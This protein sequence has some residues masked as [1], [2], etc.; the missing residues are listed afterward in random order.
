MRGL[1]WPCAFLV[2]ERLLVRIPVAGRVGIRLPNGKTVRFDSDGHDRILT[3]VYWKGVTRGHEPEVLTVFLSLLRHSRT[4]LDIGAS[5]GLYGL[6]AAVEDPARIVY[7]FEAVPCIAG[8]LERN[9]RLNDLHNMVVVRGAVSDRQGEIEIYV[10]EG[11]VPT[12]SST[13]PHFRKGARPTVVQALTIDGFA[14]AHEVGSVD[15][16][17]ADTE[18]TEDKVLAGA[19]GVLSRDE[20]IIVCEV[21]CGRTEPALQRLLLPMGYRFFHIT[22]SGLV[23]R[24]RIEGDPSYRFNNYL[25]ATERRM[26][27]V[28]ELLAR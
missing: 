10:P 23:P 2:P 19:T 6:I 21:L 28:E 12:S 15:L 1:T 25:F 13:L 9:R 18:G 5:T 27:V 17:K 26:P 22:A 16:I 14:A 20:P 11:Q 4:F 24:E 3:S 7:A 8:R